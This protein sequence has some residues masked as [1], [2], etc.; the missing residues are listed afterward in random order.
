MYLF[1]PDTTNISDMQS[2]KPKLFVP[3]PGGP[4]PGHVQC[5]E[6][7][8]GD[9][10]PQAS[11]NVRTLGE[12]YAAQW[13]EKHSH[14]DLKAEPPDEDGWMGA[15]TVKTEAEKVNGNRTKPD[16]TETANNTAAAEYRTKEYF[17]SD[18]R[19]KR[20]GGGGGEGG[21]RRRGVKENLKSFASASVPFCETIPPVLVGNSGHS[22]STSHFLQINVS[23]SSHD[24]NGS[25]SSFNPQAI[26]LSDEERFDT[27]TKIVADVN[28]HSQQKSGG[29]FAMPSV[30]DG[31]SCVLCGLGNLCLGPT[32]LG[33]TGT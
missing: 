12:R 11:D 2:S 29:T 19:I 14:Q 31:T 30:G 3:E 32:C 5:G 1:Y 24:V 26:N 10:G 8:G 13:T 23:H 21:G 9:G 15:D 6:G 4:R 17:E 33:K 28:R 16:F 7:P 27:A 20:S 18:Q 22:T 25:V